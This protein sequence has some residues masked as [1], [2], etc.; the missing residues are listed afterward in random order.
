MRKRGMSPPQ[1]ELDCS[2]AKVS[3]GLCPSARIICVAEASEFVSIA[4]LHTFKMCLL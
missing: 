1:T 4:W 2:A 3:G